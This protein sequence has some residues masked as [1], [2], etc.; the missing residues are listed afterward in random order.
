MG[1]AAQYARLRSLG[2][3]KSGAVWPRRKDVHD[4]FDWLRARDF[5]QQRQVSVFSASRP[6]TSHEK[7]TALQQIQKLAPLIQSNTV[8]PRNQLSTLDLHLSHPV[9]HAALRVIRLF[10]FLR[11]CG[12]FPMKESAMPR[13]DTTPTIPTDQDALIARE[14]SKAIAAQPVDMTSLKLQLADAGK[15]ITTVRL[16][17]AAARLLVQLLNEM[18][19]GRAVS[20]APSDVEITTQQ[21]ADLLN[22]SRP[23]LVGLVEKGELPVRMVGNQRRLPLADVLDYKARTR[24]NRLEALRELT[25]LDQELGLR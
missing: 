3:T 13:T 16:P 9:A 19:N 14:A 22:V 20:V 10:H 25:A 17:E 4:M 15:E 7:F 12:T 18:G 5:N 23:Y 8:S 24:A 6:A 21:A 1:A 11:Q 2:P